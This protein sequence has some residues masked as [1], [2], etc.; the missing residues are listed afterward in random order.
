MDRADY[1][2]ARSEHPVE[3]EKTLRKVLALLEFRITPPTASA[4]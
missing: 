2:F 1:A 4:S 3:V